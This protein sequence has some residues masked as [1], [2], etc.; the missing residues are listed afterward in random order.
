MN[1]ILLGAPGAG[2]GTQASFISKRY[3]IPHISTGD[4]LREAVS[5]S[6]PLGIKAKKY[7]NAGELVPDELVIS[8][9]KERLSEK[10]CVKG[11]L[12]DGFPRTIEQAK[13][14][15]AITKITC[16]IY[17]SVPDNIVISRLSGRRSCACGAIYHIDSARPMKEGICN[18]CGEKLFQR[19]DDNEKTVANRLTQFS[20]QT[21]PVIEYYRE[22]G[23]LKPVD[24]TK[25]IGDISKEV[26]RILECYVKD[27]VK[28]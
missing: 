22:K 28:S 11:F 25:V 21:H 17:I 18:K 19:E 2:K 26:E 3:H 8:I 24:G 16:V 20:R 6:T 13:N 27:C 7:M 5:R 10:D 23:I 15:D 1:L 4:M 9:I 12:L 14:L